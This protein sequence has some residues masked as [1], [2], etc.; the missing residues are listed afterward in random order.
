MD[1]E[2]EGFLVAGASTSVQCSGQFR[3]IV[4]CRFDKRRFDSNSS[5]L[6]FKR[7]R[8]RPAHGLELTQDALNLTPVLARAGES[9]IRVL[10]V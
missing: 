8:R 10:G 6:G 5:Y 2:I 7:D 3:S 4:G 9:Y 1:A